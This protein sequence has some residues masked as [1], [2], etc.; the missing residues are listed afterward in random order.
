VTGL[1]APVEAGATGLADMLTASKRAHVTVVGVAGAGKAALLRH[2]KHLLDLSDVPAVLLDASDDDFAPVAVMESLVSGLTAVGHRPAATDDADRPAW[3]ALLRSGS[4]ALESA[5][6]NDDVVVLMSGIDRLERL[7]DGGGTP[8]RHAADVLDLMRDHAHRFGSSTTR[9]RTAEPRIALEAGDAGEWLLDEAAWASLA[10]SAAHVAAQGPEWRRVPALTLRLLVGLAHLS[11]LPPTIPATPRHAGRALADELATHRT[12]RPVWAAWQL[13]AG[14]RGPLTDTDLDVLLADLPPAARTDP[15]LSHS[16]LFSQNGW[17]LHPILHRIVD[18]P[19]DAARARLLPVDMRRDAGRRMVNHLRSQLLHLQGQSNLQARSAAH[20]ALIDACAIAQDDSLAEG[21]TDDIPDPYDHIGRRSA[22]D[23]IRSRSAFGRARVID[24][25][26]ATAL[27][28]LADAEDREAVN[29]A[30]AE[31]LFRRVLVLE[32]QDVSSHIRLIDVLLSCGRPQ[33][34][35]DAFNDAA[36]HLDA[37][38]DAGLAEQLL[39]PVARTAIAAGDLALASRA[40]SAART[41]LSRVEA[42]ELDRLVEALVETLEY[43]EFVR[44]HRLGTRWWTAP[45]MLSDFDGDGHSLGRWLAGRIDSVLDEEASI[46]YADVPV[47]ADPNHRPERSWTTI[48]LD[49]LRAISTDEL[50]ATLEG[51]ILEIGV[52]GDG[53]RNGSTVARVAESEDIDLPDAR[54]PL[55]RYARN[56]A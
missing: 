22:E 53:E 27:R 31:A 18:S 11:A 10:P 51:T 43:G 39:L 23:P 19:P 49:D 7:A 41:S 46:H 16:I 55:D 54:L 2:T 45:E 12:T 47:P 42:R 6:R 20:A 33:A 21:L 13:I 48:S 9:P 56:A 50:P 36:G 34:A 52:Y 25:E 35:L 5:T 37:L 3:D 26:D 29:A 15:L 1:L 24:E 28:G 32:P 8:G 4:T 38:D 40:A 44:P 30:K 17:H 14:L